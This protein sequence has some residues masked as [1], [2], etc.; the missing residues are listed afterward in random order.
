MKHN[1]NT[2]FTLCVNHEEKGNYK[3][4]DEKKMSNHE[5]ITSHCTITVSTRAEK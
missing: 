4:L 2:S 1:C 5:K 3:K